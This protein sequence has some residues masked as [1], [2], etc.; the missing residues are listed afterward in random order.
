M[1]PDCYK[2]KKRNKRFRV[3]LPIIIVAIALV[4]VT[5]LHYDVLKTD[6]PGLVIFGMTVGATMSAFILSIIVSFVYKLCIYI[7]T[8]KNLFY[9]YQDA[10]NYGALSHNE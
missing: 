10:A 8:R 2:I 6:S 7:F 3:I 5:Y 9:R 1:C 4:V